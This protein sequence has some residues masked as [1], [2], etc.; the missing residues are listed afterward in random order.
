MLSIR[1]T[2]ISDKLPSPAEILMGRK[3]QTSLPSRATYTPGHNSIQRNLADRQKSQAHYHDKHAYPLRPL[4][5][6]D[7][8]TVQHPTTG[9]WDRASVIALA[10]QPRSYIIETEGGNRYRRN[11]RHLRLRPECPL[12]ETPK[13]DTPI[14]L[15]PEVLQPHQEAIYPRTRA[16]RISKPPVRYPKWTLLWTDNITGLYHTIVHAQM[17][18]L[19]NHIYICY[20]HCCAC[21]LIHVCVHCTW[22]NC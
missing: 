5:C 1:A 13:P 12:P 3:L 6:G 22:I 19:S 15:Q 17:Y 18:F 4:A 8:V 7:L 20:I 9:R 2:P 10:G 14:Q 16:G 21:T 11:R